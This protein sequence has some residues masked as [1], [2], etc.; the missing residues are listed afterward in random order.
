MR[1]LTTSND[2]ATIRALDQKGRP[3]TGDVSDVS[4]SS[5]QPGIVGVPSTVTFSNGVASLVLT[6]VSGGTAN[7]TIVGG[8]VSQTEQVEAYSPTLTTLQFDA[9]A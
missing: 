1:F 8:G 2:T 4:V 3:F 7:I 5:D 6:Q 9:A